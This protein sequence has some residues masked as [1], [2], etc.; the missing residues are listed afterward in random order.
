MWRA[1]SRH[2][3]EAAAGEPDS[4]LVAKSRLNSPTFGLLYERYRDD[5]LRYTYYCLGNWDDAAD[6]TQQIFANAFAALPRFE[7][8]NNSFRH[9]LFRIAHNEVS[10]RQHQRSRRPQ[11][12][13]D[14]AS[15]VADRS[16]SPEDLA[17]AADDHRRLWLLL[18]QLPPDRRQVCELRFV[19]LKDREIAAIL[20]K[21]E[22]AVRTAQSRA[23]AQLRVLMEQGELLGRDSR[24]S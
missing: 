3:D 12:A 2:Q 18:E 5:L 9:W 1:Q 7:D 14:D 11:S 17:I 8:R 4:V 10:S 15:E 23:V 22:G 6:A 24:T 19:G 16:P 13:I 20:G 21:T